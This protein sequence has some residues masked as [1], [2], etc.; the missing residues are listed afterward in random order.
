[1]VGSGAV[2]G[3]EQPLARRVPSSQ[4]HRSLAGWGCTRSR[5]KASRE[6]GILDQKNKAHRQ[7]LRAEHTLLPALHLGF[8]LSRQK[9]S[10]RHRRILSARA[11]PC[12]LPPHPV[13][14]LR[15][16]P[17]CRHHSP[18]ASPEFVA[19]PDQRGE[20]IFT[21]PYVAS[22]LAPPY[23]LRPPPSRNKPGLLPL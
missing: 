10:E 6:Q 21:F 8:R 18:R 3:G 7:Q 23:S 20:G 19:H 4:Q 12:P 17:P 5:Q 1:M 15:L 22:L 11:Q 14:R 9:I 2:A 13:L 16:P